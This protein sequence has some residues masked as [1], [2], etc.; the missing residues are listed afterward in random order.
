MKLQEIPCNEIAKRVLEIALVQEHSI[1]FVGTHT[2][3]LL[4]DWASGFGLKVQAIQPCSCGHLGDSI[5]VCLCSPA[6]IRR[7]YNKNYLGDFDLAL[8]VPELSGEKV[9]KMFLGEIKS[10]PEEKVL[11]RVKI[12]KK[13]L[14]SIDPKKLDENCKALLRA[15]A[16]KMHATYYQLEIVLSVAKS[17]CALARDSVIKAPYLA[18]ACQYL[19]KER[20]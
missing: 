18:E 1:R 11:E 5:K 16:L 4:G 10:E 17:I 12:A 7:Y 13:I 9:Y 15:I 20:E 19:P 2:A 14:G 8:E 6:E 3:R